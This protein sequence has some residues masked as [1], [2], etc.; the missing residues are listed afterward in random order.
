VTGLPTPPSV[1]GV[2]WRPAVLGDAQAIVDLQD[3]CFA[4]DDG[5]RETAAEIVERFD[6]PM[7]DA[8]TDSLVGVTDSG[9]MLMSLWSLIVPRPSTEVV[10]YDDN[11]IH[12][13]HRT[14]ELRTFA[15]D[16]WQARSMERALA[17]STDGQ[18]VN[19]SGHDGGSAS[20]ARL[21]QPSLPVRFH[22]H[23]Y[24]N[25]GQHID[26]I[27]RRGFTPWLYIDEMR[28]DLSTPVSNDVTPG[29]YEIV[30]SSDVPALDLLAIRNDAFRDHRGSQP[31]TIELWTSQQA[32]MH[33]A[34]ASFTA[35]AGS[36]AVAF[37]QCAVYPHDA[38]DR[39]YTEGWIEQIGTKRAHRGNGLAA[40]LIRAAM[41][42][43]ASDG[44]EYATLEVDTENPTGA[45]GLYTRLGFERVRGYVDYTRVVAG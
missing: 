36:E 17:S 31:W 9:V 5:Y 1:P 26:D 41:R 39:G 42:A 10:V 3:A 45:H 20:E 43:F 12:P 13:D 32:G 38:A 35:L 25:Q 29:R 40:A 21:R 6:S 15:L 19:G 24:P 2:T 37:V 33:R 27:T 4:A 11:Y 8:S 34:D 28:R 22:Q 18:H 7:A 16:W 30:P 44:I 23:V 14:E